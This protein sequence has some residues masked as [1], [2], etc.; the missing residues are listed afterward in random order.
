[1][2]MPT[3]EV[4]VHATDRAAPHTLRRRLALAAIGT[5]VSFAGT[6]ARAAGLAGISD[7]DATGAL[8]AAL[9]KGTEAAI[10][11]LG[12]AGGFLDDPKS[13]IPLPDALRK[14]EKILRLAGMGRDLDELVL[15][16]NRAAEAAIPQA[17]ALAIQAVRSMSVSDAKSII[18]GGDDSVTR[19][20]REKTQ[21][22]LTERF[23]PIVGKQVSR[24]GL[25]QKYDALAGQGAKF[26]LVKGD[27]ATMDGYVTERALASL[28][29]AIAEQERAIRRDPLQTGSKL[30][31]KVF[32][33]LR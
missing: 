1:M 22:S 12:R 25:A 9:E 24:L 17:K 26:G 19:F 21:R 18:T 33:A 20:F 15:A 28:Y 11:R 5:L 10:S 14:T 23:R 7:A 8:R 16:M 13:R 2:L 6:P 30:L 31:G 32:G 4:R 29:Q 3:Q 27:A